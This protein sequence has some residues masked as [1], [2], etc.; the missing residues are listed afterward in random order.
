MKANRVEPKQ[1]S[2]AIFAKAPIEGFTK[3]RLIPR[4]G[5]AGA[6]ELQRA[7]IARAIEVAKAAKLG[8]ISLWCAPD[9]THPF[10]QEVAERYSI[11]LHVQ[12][13]DDLGARMQNAFAALCSS[14]P[15]LLIGSDCVV[16][17]APLLTRCADALQNGRDAVFLPVE[18]G[19]YI[20]VGLN[21]P[22]PDLFHDMP[23]TT[24]RV[25]PETRRRASEIGLA[26][27]EPEMLWDIDRTEDYER[28]LAAGFL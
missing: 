9:C 22:I 5:A 19:G 2:M 28:A 10:F 18:D 6:A 8:P 4:L 16:I 24:E 7:L 27:E 13:G 23:W 3:T 21:K 14:M 25:M 20:L 17:D 26:I 1:T 15:V 11:T 12:I